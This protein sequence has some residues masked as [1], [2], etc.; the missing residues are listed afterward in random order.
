M[1]SRR[2][3]GEIA[4]NRWKITFI[5]GLLS[6][7]VVGCFTPAPTDEASPPTTAPGGSTSAP[8]TP[9]SSDSAIGTA[10]RIA[11]VVELGHTNTTL[12]QVTGTEDL[13]AGDF[14]R[15]QNGG[16]SLLDFGDLSFT[17]FNDSSMDVVTAERGPEGSIERLAFFLGQGGVL[18]ELNP[19]GGEV[20]WRTPT[21][22]EITVTGTQFVIAY[23]PDNQMLMVGNFGGHIQWATDQGRSEE[24]TSELQS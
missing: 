22:A 4:M 16:R 18:G 6:L 19:Q 11:D 7:V 15:I 21:G 14:L 12:Q 20:T 23:E 24:H 17:L 5:L 10:T 9:D 8:A 2:A 1:G 13:F 3:K